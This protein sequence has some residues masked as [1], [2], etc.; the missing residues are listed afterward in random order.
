MTYLWP[1]FLLVISKMKQRWWSLQAFMGH[2]LKNYH[3]KYRSSFL[4]GMLPTGSKTWTWPWGLGS[5]PWSRWVNCSSRSVTWNSLNSG[6]RNL[7]ARKDNKWHIPSV[8]VRILLDC[9]YPSL[10]LATLATVVRTWN[11]TFPTSALIF[12]LLS[13]CSSSLVTLWRLGFPQ[14]TQQQLRMFLILRVIVICR[15]TVHHKKEG[16]EGNIKTLL[17][18]TP[19]SPAALNTEI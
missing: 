17:R 19:N 10:S 13:V 8:G 4:S 3:S 2:C 7:E 9:S 6:W 12:L 18:I 16:W 15:A 14:G 11:R 5:R 1:C